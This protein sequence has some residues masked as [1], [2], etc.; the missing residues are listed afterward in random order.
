MAFVLN[1]VITI[2]KYHFKGVNDLVIKKNVHVIV[3][4]A[5]LKIP[6][7][8]RIPTK[9]TFTDEVQNSVSE[10]IAITTALT[11]FKLDNK[12][13]KSSVE[14]AVLFNEGDKVSI[15]LGYNGDLRNEFRGF[16]RRINQTVPLE[17]E[18]E[19]YAFQLRNKTVLKSWKKTNVK[20]VLTDVIKGTDVILSP[21]IPDIPLPYFVSANWTG[22]RILE[23]LKEKMLLTVCFDDNVLFVGIEEGRSIS[24]LGGDKSRTGLAEVVY[25][26]GYNCPT[27]QPNLKRRLGKDDRVLV[28]IRSR[29]KTGKTIMY[30]AGDI[31]GAVH[32]TNMQFA[33]D[34]S[35]LQL[36][37]EAKLKRLKYDGYEGTLIGFLQP[38][39]K[40]GWKAILKDEKYVGAG[41]GTYF[42]A[43]TEV[44]FGAKGGRRMVSI[45]YRLDA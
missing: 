44:H 24:N 23:Y 26:I 7:L 45:T 43:G 41:I 36:M 42:I 39:C 19:G 11:G 20:E 29:Q 5:K 37:A 22:L 8:S 6:A 28:R 27:N 16:V 18:M 3:D 9:T 21:D 32:T 17:I 15:D 12:L 2:G 38:F 10:V 34:P 33:S 31:D 1:S 4:T 25:N 35:V 30:E 14:T 40:P 13:P